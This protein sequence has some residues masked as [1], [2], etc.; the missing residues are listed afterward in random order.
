MTTPSEI[1]HLP[2]RLP[3]LLA[4]FRLGFPRRFAVPEPVLAM[5]ATAKI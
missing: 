4:L 5:L 2:R 3:I 1:S